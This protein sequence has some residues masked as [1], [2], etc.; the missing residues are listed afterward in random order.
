MRKRLQ[1]AL[2]LIGDPGNLSLANSKV[3]TTF[4]FISMGNL[5]KDYVSERFVIVNKPES[6]KPKTKK[7]L[8]PDVPILDTNF[9]KGF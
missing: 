1:S 9:K 8:K 7:K 5:R 3:S 4:F 6:Q 2:R